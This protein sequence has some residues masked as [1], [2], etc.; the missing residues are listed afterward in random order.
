MKQH[1][2]DVED[3]VRR[4]RQSPITYA[5]H[6]YTS[7]NIRSTRPAIIDGLHVG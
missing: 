3:R 1:T 6:E 7:T 2:S 5:N 4:Y